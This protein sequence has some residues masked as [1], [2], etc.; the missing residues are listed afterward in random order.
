[1]HNLVRFGIALI[2][3]SVFCLMLLALNAGDVYA[4][5]EDTS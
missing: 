4:Y 1:M 2:V 3:V 5:E